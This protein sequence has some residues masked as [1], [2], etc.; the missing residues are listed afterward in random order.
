[1]LNKNDYTP[2]K[3]S[4]DNMNMNI[5]NCLII[6]VILKKKLDLSMVIE[7]CIIFW[8]EYKIKEKKKKKKLVISLMN[9]IWINYLKE[10]MSLLLQRHGPCYP[11]LL[12]FQRWR[13]KNKNGE[14]PLMV[15][16]KYENINIIKH[17]T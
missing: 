14:T 7:F 10:I 1:M 17:L 12:H 3:K 5:F 15:T 8:V 2:L 4:F 16:I 6:N 9:N 13:S 11:A